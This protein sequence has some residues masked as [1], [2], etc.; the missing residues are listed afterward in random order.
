LI[1]GYY[2][3][4][5]LRY[6]SK[7]GTGFTDRQ[8]RDFL[9]GVAQIQQREC[10]FETIPETGRSR[11]GYG[12]TAEERRTAVWLKP[13]LVCAVRFTEWPDDG[14]LRHP[15]FEG[16]RLEIGAAQNKRQ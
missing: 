10:P 14:H 2:E 8:I 7:V 5:K 6:G 4:G 16:W 9:Q 1:V 3:G 12:L 15:L 11:W 13:M